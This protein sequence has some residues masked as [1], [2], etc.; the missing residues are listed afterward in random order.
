M[1]TASS[2]VVSGLSPQP[3]RHLYG[4]SDDDLATYGACRYTADTSPG[5]PDRIEMRDA[6]V[7]ET[8]L[9]VNHVS[10]GQDTP[11][12]TSHAIFVCEGAQ[13]TYQ[14]QNTI[15][16]V[17]SRRLLSLRAFDAE[18]MMLD[19]ELAEG[20]AISQTVQRLLV[21]PKTDRIH[22]HYALRGCYAGL[23]TRS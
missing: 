1:F 2:F 22:A 17:M 21:R 14:A 16:Q 12:K 15:P 5:F 9:L 19:A 20:D 13:D 6:E 4:L 23:I 10:M 11:Y 3:Y 8:L 7:G 18:G